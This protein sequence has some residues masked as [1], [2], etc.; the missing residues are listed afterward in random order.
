[1]YRTY[2]HRPALYAIDALWRKVERLTCFA[3]SDI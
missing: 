2:L 3:T 1:M